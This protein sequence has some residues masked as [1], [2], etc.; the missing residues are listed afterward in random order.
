MSRIEFIYKKSLRESQIEEIV[1]PTGYLMIST[2]EQ[3]IFDIIKHISKSG[4]INSVATLVSELIEKIRPVK[5]I[6]L[7]KKSF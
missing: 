2:P 4:G 3:T 7:A 6:E 1:M 5:L